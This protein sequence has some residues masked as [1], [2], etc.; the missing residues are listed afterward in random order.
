MSQET[1]KAASPTVERFNGG[2]A[3]WLEEADRS[4][5]R[6]G[7]AYVSDTGEV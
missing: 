2:T 3:S 7:R 4:L 5:C 6:D 1:G